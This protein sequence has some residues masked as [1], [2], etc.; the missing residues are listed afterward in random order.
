M[1]SPEEVE[2]AHLAALCNRVMAAPADREP[3]V[4]VFAA[5][6]FPIEGYFAADPAPAEA[7][8]AAGAAAG[9]AAGGAGGGAGAGAGAGA[10]AVSGSS[11]AAAASAT[12]ASDESAA[13]SML[14][15]SSRRT[16]LH[17]RSADAMEPC[18]WSM[19]DGAMAAQRKPSGAATAPPGVLHG[20][21]ANGSPVLQHATVPAL[22]GPLHGFLP[23]ALCDLGRLALAQVCMCHASPNTQSHGSVEC[24]RSTGTPQGC[25]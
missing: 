25:H 13:D 14:E 1:Y 19:N 2:A 24:V 11:G 8:A 21:A 6:Q 18:A 23:R 7:S 5:L 15:P 3:A 4:P 10:R 16:C 17:C 20:V 12:H 22:L 9:V